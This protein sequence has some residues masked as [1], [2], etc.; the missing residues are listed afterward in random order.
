M[1]EKGQEIEKDY[2]QRLVKFIFIWSEKKR[3]IH[4]MSQIELS[5]YVKIVMKIN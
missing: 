2:L 5:S 3:I 1:F 4:I